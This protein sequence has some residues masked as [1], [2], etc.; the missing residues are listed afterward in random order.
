[1][2]NPPPLWAMEEMHRYANTATC[3]MLHYALLGAAP[4]AANAHIFIY[5]FLSAC[6]GSATGLSHS[7]Q[8]VPRVK[9]WVSG[10]G[11]GGRAAA[12]TEEEVRPSP[13]RPTVATTSAVSLKPT[14]ILS[15]EANSGGNI[16][17]GVDHRNP[18]C[19]NKELPVLTQLF[20]RAM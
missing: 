12:E 2:P 14:G 19:P 1:M 7:L 15:S 11:E 9:W 3:A 5:L 6:E 10:R 20:L 17:L 4:H 18:P 16:S 13:A 8:A